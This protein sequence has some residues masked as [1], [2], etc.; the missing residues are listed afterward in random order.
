MFVFRNLVFGLNLAAGMLV[1]LAPSP[2]YA[3]GGMPIPFDCGG[4]KC[5]CVAV[6]SGSPCLAVVP[7]VPDC[8]TL[9]E[10]GRSNGQLY[11]VDAD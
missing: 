9:C 10:C 3:I 6:A 1:L 4:G 5:T 11:C 7:P 8:G 2:V